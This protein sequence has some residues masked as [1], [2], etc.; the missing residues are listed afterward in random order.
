MASIEI[1][2]SFASLVAAKAA[3]KLVISEKHES[4]IIDYSDKTRFRIMCP[5]RKQSDCDFQVRATDSKKH[6]VTITHTKPHTGSRATH[7][8]ARNTHAVQFLLPHRKASVVDNPKISIKKIQSNERLQFKNTISYQQAYRLKQVILQELWGDESEC[9]AQFPDYINRCKSADPQN[10]AYLDIGSNNRFNAVL[11]AS[12]GLRH[13]GRHLRGFTAI[14]GTHTKSTYRMILLIACGIDANSNVVPLAW[15]LV[16]IEDEIWW[17]W[18][19]IYLRASYPC[20]SIIY[21][22]K[23][24]TNHFHRPRYRR[25]YFHFRS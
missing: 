23:F 19:L 8:E 22:S 15:A 14:D 6:G 10:R 7:F 16:P 9:F 3:I 2:Q 1:G 17:N 25:S 11:F 24:Y 20:E 4:F 21:Y 5:M 18:F 13:A 12:A